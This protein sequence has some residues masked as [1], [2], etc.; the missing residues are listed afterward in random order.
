MGVHQINNE[1][2]KKSTF[3]NMLFS[4]YS[5]PAPKMD[6]SIIGLMI[7]FKCDLGVTAFCMLEVCTL[8]EQYN[9]TEVIKLY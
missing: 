7:D 3:H 9:E 6:H 8:H 4:S 1:K 5:H 2:K